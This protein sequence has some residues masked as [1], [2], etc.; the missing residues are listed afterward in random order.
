MKSDEERGGKKIDITRIESR[1]SVTSVRFVEGLARAAGARVN[2]RERP[3]STN[4]V[5]RSGGVPI[6]T[7]RTFSISSIYSWRSAACKRF[8]YIYIYVRS[9]PEKAYSYR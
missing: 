3:F 6:R 2:A 8:S 1:P 9:G 7:R 5:N 4:V